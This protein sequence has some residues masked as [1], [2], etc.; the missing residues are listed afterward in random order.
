MQY[1][2]VHTTFPRRFRRGFVC[3]SNRRGTTNYT[4]RRLA[5]HGRRTRLLAPP[6]ARRPSP[7][8]EI[9]ATPT[10]TELTNIRHKRQRRLIPPQSSKPASSTQT[11]QLALHRN[12]NIPN[13]IHADIPPQRTK[14]SNPSA[15]IA[16]CLYVHLFRLGFALSRPHRRKSPQKPS[17]PP[18]SAPKIRKRCPQNNAE[19]RNSPL[20]HPVIGG[21]IATVFVCVVTPLSNLSTISSP[22]S[23]MPATFRRATPAAFRI[24]AHSHNRYRQ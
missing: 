22:H 23:L 11:I 5:A 15:Y 2:T 6:S 1:G 3:R 20:I 14:R 18:A 19:N 24:S 17:K 8:K 4:P 21:K 9:P 12:I 10:Q 13:R 7:S 16:C